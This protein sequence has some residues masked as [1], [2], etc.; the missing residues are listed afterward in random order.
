VPSRWI[1]LVGF[2]KPIAAVL[3]RDGVGGV[4]TATFERDVSFHEIVTTW[5]PPRALAFTIKVDPDFIP[6]TAFDQHIIV[7]GRFFDV[8]DGRYEIESL[9]STTSRLRLTSHHRLTT[10]FNAYAGW[11][12]EKIMRQ[13]QGS[14]LEVIRARAE[15]RAAAANVAA[16]QP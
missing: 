8:L 2:P 13:I 9:S 16:V 3:D 15:K 12:S 4:R 11:W 5:E 1:Y 14:I 10:R 6:H 7:G